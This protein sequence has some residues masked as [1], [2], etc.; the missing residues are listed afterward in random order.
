MKSINRLL[1]KGRIFLSVK[2]IERVRQIGGLV[3]LLLEQMQKYPITAII[4]ICE[5]I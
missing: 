4:R 3:L 5:K 1:A 2:A